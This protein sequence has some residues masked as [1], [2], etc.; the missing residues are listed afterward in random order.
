MMSRQGHIKRNL[1]NKILAAGAAVV[2]GLGGEIFFLN[3]SLSWRRHESTGKF[4]ASAVPKGSAKSSESEETI[5]SWA[6]PD[7]DEPPPWARDDGKQ[8]ATQESF[9]IPFYVYLIGSAITAIAAIGSVF[10]YLNKNPVFGVLESD[11]FFY[12]PLLGFFFFTGI[13]TSG[14]LWLKSVQAANKEAEEQ[15]KRDGFL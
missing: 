6:D 9:D 13:P 14:F 2:H 7:A 8:S 5:P 1:S 12:T 4:S 10:E 11:N 15:D 3:Q